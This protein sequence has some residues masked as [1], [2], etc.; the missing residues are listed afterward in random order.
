MSSKDGFRIFKKKW[1]YY[2]MNKWYQPITHTG[3]N[4][5]ELAVSYLGLVDDK[6]CIR[7]SYENLKRGNYGRSTKEIEHF[8]NENNKKYHVDFLNT[9]NLTICEFLDNNSKLAKIIG[10]NRETLVFI[11][12]YKY[13]IGH[14]VVL[15]VIDDP[16]M[17]PEEGP[18]IH[19][20]DTSFSN[21]YKGNEIV[22]YLKE[23]HFYTEEKG[24]N[25]NFLEIRPN[26]DSFRSTIESESANA[27]LNSNSDNSASAASAPDNN[28]MNSLK[29]QVKKFSLSPKSYVKANPK[30]KKQRKLSRNN[31]S[32][33]KKKKGL[34]AGKS[35]RKIGIKPTTFSKALNSLKIS[36]SVLPRSVK[37]KI[38]KNKSVKK[39][40]SVKSFNSSPRL[41]DL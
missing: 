26:D 6:I 13:K 29:R 14:Y 19:L 33:S 10:K 35:S 9:H 32:A 25:I 8:I 24:V 4:C 12:S 7:D 27:S 17:V 21:Y 37:S 20:L 39:S 36:Q 30:S 2:R 11:R 23:N 22:K 3:A 41:S 38:N 18:Q 5:G 28:G 1:D 16:R 34:P 40:K 31:Y 15:S